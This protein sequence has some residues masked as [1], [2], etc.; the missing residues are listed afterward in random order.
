MLS[1]LLGVEDIIVRI[2]AEHFC[3]RLRGVK[4]T[5]AKTITLKYGG[6]YNTGEVRKEF[7]SEISGL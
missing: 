1:N 2:E 4:H 5:G 3:V 6:Y 7:L